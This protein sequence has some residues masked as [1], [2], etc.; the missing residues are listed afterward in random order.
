MRSPITTIPASRSS[1]SSTAPTWRCRRSSRAYERPPLLRG[2][3][4]RREAR[5]RLD[6]HL[7]RQPCRLCGAGAGGGLPC[8]RRKAA[9]DDGR[10]RRARRRGGQG[11]RPQAGDRL[12]PAPPPVL[13]AA[14]RRGA[15]A[16]RSLR[17]PHEPQ[18]A[19]Q[20]ADL[21]DAQAAD[22]DD[23]A[24]RRL[25]R[26]LC[27]R[28]VP[29]HRRQAGRGARHGAAAVRRDR[30]GHVQLRPSAG[31]VRRR[32][33]RLVRGRLGADDLGDGVLREG[34]D[35]AQGLRLHRHGAKAPSRTTSTPTP[36]P[37]PSAC[38]ARHLDRT[39]SSRRPT[40]TCRWRASRATRSCATSSRRSC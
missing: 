37:R 35:L 26:A 12:H 23:L 2:G 1:R 36:R 31:A 32:L 28:D 8:L 25:R 33:G 24:D 34:R 18:P 9:G 15:E 13:D 22:A 10:R 6:Q 39:A 7:F 16:R 5:R 29:D 14:D 21:G 4:A 17:F 40:E 30:S 19:V 27:R 11:Q 3:A 38:T 20:R